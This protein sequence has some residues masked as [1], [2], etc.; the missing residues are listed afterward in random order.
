MSSP[1]AAEMPAVKLTWYDGGRRPARAKEAGFPDWSAGVLFVGS[2]GML[3]AN[4]SAYKLLPEKEFAGFTSPTKTIPDSIG[5][6]REWIEA[7]QE[8]HADNLQLR[9]QRRPGRSGAAGDR[10]LS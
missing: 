6:H 9:L 7:L 2:K 4:Y 1:L 8:G 10:C 5:H 3:L